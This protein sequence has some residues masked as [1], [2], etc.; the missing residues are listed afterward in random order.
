MRVPDG[1]QSQMLMRSLNLSTERLQR[2]Q[3]EVASGLRIQA[4]SDDPSGA[5]RAAALRSGLA[6]TAEYLK[7]AKT[8]TA[9]L[10]SED[11]ALGNLTDALRQ[12]RNYAL[13]GNNTLPQESRDVLTRQ[14]K[15][16]ADTVMKALNGSDG[17]RS[18]FSGHKTTTTPFQGTAPGAV[19]YSGDDGVRVVE[20]GDGIQLDLNHSGTELANLG[21]AADA[22]VPDLFTTI[23]NLMTAVSTGDTAAVATNLTDLDT[24]MTR[25]NSVRAETGIKLEQTSVA[26][27]QLSK[28]DITLTDLLSD[29]EN[30][31]ITESL[32]HLKEQENLYQA[33]SYMASQL[34]KGGLMDWIR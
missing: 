4:P 14:I 6:Q 2:Y 31:D 28:L 30:A 5:Q 26:Q 27:D 17:T 10:K 29:I 15:L 34:G 12:I 11:V 23:N 3:Q 20:I 16:A 22:S 18:L 13:Q 7:T 8:A 32:V 1:I 21:G 9:W 25:V 33:A 24:H 19:T